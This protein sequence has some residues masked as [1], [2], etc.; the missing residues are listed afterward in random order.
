MP[1][2]RSSGNSRCTWFTLP[3][4]SVTTAR[5][6]R[7]ATSMGSTG[8]SPSRCSAM[9]ADFQSRRRKAKRRRP[10]SPMLRCRRRSARQP[11]M[12]LHGRCKVSSESDA[13]RRL[14]LPVFLGLGTFTL[15]LFAAA[16][17]RANCYELIGCSNKDRYK[18]SDLMQ[19]GCQPLWEVRNWIYKETGYGSRTPKAIEP[20]GNSGCRYEN[21]AQ[22]PP[23]DTERYN[24]RT[25][26]SVEIKKGC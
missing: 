20:S 7:S 13:M 3:P 22:V 5:L 16:P 15:S 9:R 24:M 6:R 23:N 8:R 19:L 2:L 17:A 25:I 21:V 26:K 11:T 12:T 10:E 1:R 18:I 14:V 4:W